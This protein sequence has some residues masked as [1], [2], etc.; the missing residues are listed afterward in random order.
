MVY[1]TPHTANRRVPTI[2]EISFAQWVGSLRNADSPQI[3]VT[4]EQAS[5]ESSHGP[6]THS[7]ISKLYKK[8][9]AKQVRKL[10]CR[11]RSP[12]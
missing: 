5:I 10:R 6:G 9:L 12:A 11:G 1:I 7:S 4:Y 8:W 2:Q 3:G